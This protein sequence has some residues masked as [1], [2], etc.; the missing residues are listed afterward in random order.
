[1]E[2]DTENTL[3]PEVPQWVF[4]SVQEIWI[5]AQVEAQKG[6]D[7]E[8]TNLTD[9]IKRLRAENARLFKESQAL[10]EELKQEKNR[11]QELEERLKKTSE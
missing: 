9:A 5:A 10:K 4:K 1:M 8:K 6:Y 7:Q 11:C 2:E 3:I